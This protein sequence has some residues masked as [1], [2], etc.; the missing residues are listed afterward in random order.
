[1]AENSELVYGIRPKYFAEV[2]SGGVKVNVDVVEP[3]GSETF[4]YCTMGQH[5]LCIQ[6]DERQQVSAGDVIEV[7]PMME[8]VLLFDPASGNRIL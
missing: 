7:A 6:F 3:T 8:M 4:A 5:P 2:E 1:M